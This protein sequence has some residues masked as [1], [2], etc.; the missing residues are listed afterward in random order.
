MSRVFPVGL[1]PTPMA[2]EASTLSIALRE[3]TVLFYQSLTVRSLNQ[4]YSTAFSTTI[5]KLAAS[6]AMAPIAAQTG[7][8]IT[9]TTPTVI[10]IS[11]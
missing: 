5:L 6:A 11:I 2:S 7:S 1:E 4:C 10:G 8:K 9:P 3:R